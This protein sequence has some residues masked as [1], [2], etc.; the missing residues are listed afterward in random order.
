MRRGGKKEKKTSGSKGGVGIKLPDVL[1]PP[2]VKGGESSARSERE[3]DV[4]DLVVEGSR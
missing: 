2:G 3:V 1:L 4:D